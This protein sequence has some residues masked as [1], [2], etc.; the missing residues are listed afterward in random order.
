MIAQWY[1]KAKFSI[2]FSQHVFFISSFKIPVASDITASFQPVQSV[3]GEEGQLS[4]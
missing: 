1:Q 3:E 2:L 4:L